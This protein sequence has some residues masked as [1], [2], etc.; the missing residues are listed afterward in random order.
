MA[1]S[2]KV[3]IGGIL[4]GVSRMTSFHIFPHKKRIAQFPAIRQLSGNKAE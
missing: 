3:K 4:I 1:I 2:T